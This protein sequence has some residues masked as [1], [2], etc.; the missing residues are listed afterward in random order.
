MTV[1][2]DGRHAYAVGG[3]KNGVPALVEFARDR[4]TG[5]PARIACVA[6]PGVKGCGRAR[7]LRGLESIALSANGKT[8][9]AAAWLSHAVASFHIAG[10]GTL[11]QLRGAD[12]CLSAS[13]RERSCRTAR[14]L[15]QPE[16]EVSRDGRNVYVVDVVTLATDRR[17]GAPRELPSPYGCMNHDGTQGCARYRA[18]RGTMGGPVLS[19]DGRYL[20]VVSDA[21][22]GESSGA[23]GS[24]AVFR[25]R[26]G[27]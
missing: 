8:L 18:L 25:R 15:F 26:T 11:E 2:P 23:K 6:E 21:L 5:A 1:A 10:N 20:Y 22:V 4:S 27:R 19:P 3:E 14:G 17:T 24:I 16:L 12:G 9:Y 7:G 13:R